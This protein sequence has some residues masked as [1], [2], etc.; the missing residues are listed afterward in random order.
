MSRKSQ[1]AALADAFLSVA[2][3]TLGRAYVVMLALGAFASESGHDAVAL[4]YVPTLLLLV[5]LML[6]NPPVVVGK[7]QA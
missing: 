5:V 6:T 7:A 3:V 1:A 2:V 4:G